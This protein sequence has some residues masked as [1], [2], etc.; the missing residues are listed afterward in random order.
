MWVQKY[1][2]CN[3]CVRAKPARPGPTRRDIGSSDHDRVLPF[4][5]WKGVTGEQR[6]SH[7]SRVTG[8]LT[9]SAAGDEDYIL[10]PLPPPSPPR[11]TPRLKSCGTAVNNPASPTHL[12]FFT[13]SISFTDGR[14]FKL[15]LMPVLFQPFHWPLIGAEGLPCSP[16]GLAAAGRPG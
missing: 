6:P 5:I 12:F 11:P 9:F 15:T 4:T 8:G 13:R 1:V 10:R 2:Y 3:N 14:P 16:P 7:A